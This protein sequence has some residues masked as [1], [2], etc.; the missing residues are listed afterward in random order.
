[1][2]LTA[3]SIS[4]SICSTLQNFSELYMPP[5]AATH[6]AIVS[7]DRLF[8]DGLVEVLAAQPDFTVTTCRTTSGVPLAQLG[9][10]HDII[11]VDAR[12]D[13]PWI[14]GRAIPDG[15]VVIFVGASED[16]TW[17]TMALTLGARGILTRTA[18]RDDLVQ[19]IRTVHA[20]GIWARRRWLN[21]CVLYVVGASKH[22]MATLDTVDARLSPR[23][24][25]VLQHAATG[26]GNKELADRLSISEATVKVHLTHIFQKLGVPGRAAL[27][28]AYHQI[29]APD[30]SLVG[31]GRTTNG[32]SR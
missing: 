15:A 28:A 31:A 21:A 14:R 29:G 17:A 27:A 22:R 20:G 1:M 19:A 7:D 6:I 8:C 10:A 18:N 16:D 23:E 4:R 32:V 11:L 5:Q 30:D 9:A 24:R 2:I 3:G 25:E 13:A 26:V 12:G